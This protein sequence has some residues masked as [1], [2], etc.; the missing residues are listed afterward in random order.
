MFTPIG[1]AFEVV[2][3]HR[4][5]TAQEVWQRD[6]NSRRPT[7]P[8]RES[9]FAFRAAL[10]IALASAL[11]LLAPASQ[12]QEF[13]GT[14]SG[15]VADPSGAVVPGAN[16]TIT[17]LRT[18]TASKTVS[19]SAGQY[20]VPFL[21]PGQY[22][23]T[24]EKA[25]FSR[26]VRNNISLDAG[27]HLVLD[28][29]VHVGNVQETVQVT[30]AV[31]LLNTANASIGQTITEKEVGDLPLNG[32]SPMMLAQLA[33][34]VIATSYP[35]SQNH[36]FDN[37]A[38]AAWSIAG[39]PSQ[40]SELLMDGAPDE[41][42][43]GALAYSPP[44]DAVQEVTVK[45]FDTDA[46]YGHTQS[47]VL[48]Q[49]LRTGTNGL[50]GTAYEFSQVSALDANS[51]FNDQNNQ[52]NPVTH[53]N[54]YGVTA[55]GPVIIPK[56][57][58]GRNKLFWF[59]AWEGLKDSQPST[60][61]ATV[62]TAAERTGD[63]SA[64]LPLGCPSGY[65][66]GNSAICANGSAN[67]YQLYNPFTATQ[68]GKTITRQPIANNILGNAGI[69]INPIAAAYLNFYPQPNAIGLA[70]G[71]NNYISSPPS[72]DNYNNE[73]GRLDWNVSTRNHMFFDFRHN[74]R[75]QLKN[76]YFNN[77]ATG[78]TLTR[79][80]WGGTLDDVYALNTSTVLDVRANW[81][82][83]REMHGSPGDG[84]NPTSLGF[85]GYMASSSNFLALPYIVFGS[86]G[87]QTSFQCLGNNGD[88]LVPS[89]SYQMFGDV[90][91]LIGKH[92][93]KVGVD[94]R[95][96]TMDAITYGVPSGSFNFGTNWVQQT[97][98][99][100]APQW[101]GDFASFLMGLPNNSSNS[102]Y[103]INARGSYAAYYMAGFVQDD[104]RITPTL[105][106]NLGLRFDHDSPFSEKFGRTVDGFDTTAQSPIAAAAQAAYAVNPN[107][108]L[109]AADFNVLGGLSF[110]NPSSGDVYQ[111]SSNL[112]SPRVGFAWSPSL[113]NNRTVVRGGFGM[114]VSQMT[115]ASLAASSTGGWS[116]TPIINN[117]GFSAT[118]SMV[119]TSNSYLSPAT[120]LSDPY[121]GGAILQPVG[122]SAGLST[123]LGQTVS[124]IAPQVHDPY[125]MRWNFGIQQTLTPNLLIEVDYVGNHM[126]H[127]PVNATQLNVVP[128]QYLSTLTT[129][130]QTV[131]NTLTATTANPFL[132]LF[133]GSSLGTGKTISV[134]QLLSA[135]PE[136]PSGSGSTST[137][138]IEQNAT[139]GQG[140][141]NALEAHVQQRLSHGLW[142][143][144]NYSFSKLETRDAWLNDTDTV[145]NKHIS[146]FDHT[147]HLAAGFTYNLPIGRDKAIPLNSRWADALLGG[148]VVNGIYTYQ[149]GA[150]LYWSTDM[151][152]DGTP[153]T[154]DPR[155]AAS[156]VPAFNTG[157]FATVSNQQFQYH[158]RTFPLTFSNLRQDGL[159]NLD[160]SILKEFHFTESRY[161][162][163]R[164]EAFNTLNRVTFNAPNLTP[165][166]KS[167]GL[168]TGE[169]NVNR[170]V[171]LGGRIVF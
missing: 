10:L 75:S 139:I 41:I 56:V 157:A 43:S 128:R 31:P 69:S 71:E 72:I 129:R 149:S 55:G 90:V 62:P 166:N 125:S 122:S 80:N 18:G 20:V 167:F 158:V 95:K 16:I 105:T 171:Q 22:E 101:A 25:G 121:P 84:V 165:T 33:V 127:T 104:W 100:A 58:D 119:A 47:G 73:L 5:R 94:A 168:I 34:G 155:Q 27:Q 132:G 11:L 170:G 12:A 63:F 98:S 35:S 40:T 59:F 96:Y 118:T 8:A 76:D 19:D 114:F 42:W 97:S 64:L 110:P 26:V 148:W 81:T 154:L 92:T 36:P 161:F 7:G 147:H 61:L 150:P 82:Y 135:Y 66:G 130:D 54:Q 44:Q 87:S 24:A 99:A 15:R 144:A 152:W 117:E 14:I 156:G 137:G 138:V 134:A 2:R 60:D 17:E 111:V 145:L 163:L 151:V 9:S 78:V 86:C 6:E 30:E 51:Y 48:N 123:F 38:M 4:T 109:P 106:L 108:Q 164:L 124:F 136:F 116:S 93:L 57:Y 1:F 131:I 39:S 143:T 21:A 153:I 70:D 74:L 160:A 28:L 3:P 50:H 46:S 103:T 91:K 77:P 88:S 49:I 79:E 133:S 113:L 142:F 53:F 120:T 89:Q 52:P 32:R 85:P 68:S 23:I 107:A 29:T 13:R 141:F 45:A 126:V 162:Q 159:N 140:Y 83:M 102:A 115:M 67:P 65:Q 169:A 37:N 146:P 112:F